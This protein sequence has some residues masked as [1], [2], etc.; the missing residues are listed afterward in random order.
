MTDRSVK[1][2]TMSP[3]TQA[4]NHDI[5]TKRRRDILMVA[6]EL[7]ATHGYHN[8]SV[9]ELAKR[10]GIS[11]GLLYN[12]FHSK[13]EVLEAVIRQQFSD[14]AKQ[15]FDE[16][17]AL[18]GKFAPQELI[19]LGVEKYFELLQAQEQVWR[20]SISLSMQVSNLPHIREVMNEV[21][22]RIF[23][24]ME[25]MFSRCGLTHTYHRARLLAA[26]LDGIALHYYAFPQYDLQGVK[27]QLIQ[28][29]K[30]SL[31]S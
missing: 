25:E 28:D 1:K 8:T 19:L 3:R 29:I 27:A 13:E 10:A 5:R 9:S 18:E 20:L 7:F 6:L 14:S 21:F 2:Y 23:L 26:Q 15:L 17:Q 4:Q 12:Y 16:L 22:H 11:K 24:L 30:Q 31:S